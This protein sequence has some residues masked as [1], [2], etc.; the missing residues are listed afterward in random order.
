MS[1]TTLAP[2]QEQ[3]V[4]QTSCPACGHRLTLHGLLLQEAWCI[5]WDG[6][7]FCGCQI[8]A[9]PIDALAEAVS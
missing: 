5:A 8:P 7:A 6:R 1:V 3:T 4:T 2:R 9:A